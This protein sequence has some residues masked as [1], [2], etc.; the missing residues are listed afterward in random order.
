MK[1]NNLCSVCIILEA[2]NQL[3][4]VKELQKYMYVLNFLK[5]FTFVVLNELHALILGAFSLKANQV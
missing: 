4:L 2:V 1:Q 3:F 5:L